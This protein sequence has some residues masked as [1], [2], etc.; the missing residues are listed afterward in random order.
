[1]RDRPRYY[2]LGEDNHAVAVDDWK[3]WALWFEDANRVVDY[4]E[5]TSEVYV[6]TVFLGIDHRHVGSGPPLL[7]ETMIFG[8]EGDDLWMRRY[9]SWDDAATGH[10]VIVGKL[11]AKQATRAQ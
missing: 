5:I 11:R 10:T 9:S 3:E 2:I 7:F 8:A 4:T 1:M 6:S